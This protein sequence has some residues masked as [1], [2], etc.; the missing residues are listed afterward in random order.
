MRDLT[1][2]IDTDLLLKHTTSNRNFHCFFITLFN[3]KLHKNGNF[4][5]I[6]SNFN[7]LKFD[8]CS[9]SLDRHTA[10]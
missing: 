10:F 6:H 3:D 9:K 8:M 7:T 1:L 2:K 4:F 5:G